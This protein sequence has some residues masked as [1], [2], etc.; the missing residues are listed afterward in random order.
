MMTS[1]V[2]GK[3]W[4]DNQKFKKIQGTHRKFEVSLGYMR[5]CLED[6]KE[7]ETGLELQFS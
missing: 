7:I 2:F 1:P 5:S 4:Q 6:E 3:R